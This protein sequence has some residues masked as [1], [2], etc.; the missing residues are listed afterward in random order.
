[1]VA[2][3]SRQLH[4]GRPRAALV[5]GGAL[6]VATLLDC[7]SHAAARVRLHSETA[8][9][10]KLLQVPPPPPGSPE[11]QALANQN[12]WGGAQDGGT[13]FTPVN[14]EP[15][16]PDQAV[17]DASAASVQAWAAA[18]QVAAKSK[19]LL[20]GDAPLIAAEVTVA[21]SA[22]DAAAKEDAQ[23]GLLLFA[24][25]NAAAKSAMAAASNYLEQVK[26]A[27]NIAVA[28]AMAAKHGPDG[29]TAAAHRALAASVPFKF[30]MLRGQ[31][32]VK[33]YSQRAQALAMASNRLKTESNDMA[34]SAQRL[35]AMGNVIMA[36]R[37]M[38]TAHSLVE[39]AEAMEEEAENLQ[40]LAVE[41]NAVLPTYKDMA[42]AAATGAALAVPPTPMPV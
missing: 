16:S 11:A 2:M 18:G 37:T 33:S 20:G 28:A 42:Q 35:Q 23:L 24:T 29:P 9:V 10:D 1:M 31:A 15:V 19:E 30:Q 8:T 27:A 13:I 4:V 40:A 26:N 5:A 22:A 41:G 12:A 3:S 25:R 21:K 14:G 32:I 6:V 36:N 39:Q 38:T 34:V 17:A 7:F